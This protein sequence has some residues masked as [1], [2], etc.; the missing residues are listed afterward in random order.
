MKKLSL[1]VA[2]AVLSTSAFADSHNSF[3][4]TKSIADISISHSESGS[5]EI[6]GLELG[7]EKRFNDIWYLEVAAAKAT[8]KLSEEGKKE[9]LEGYTLAGGA[10]LLVPI[11]NKHNAL[12][13]VGLGYG[14][15]EI[16]KG[17]HKPTELDGFYASLGF[18]TQLSSPDLELHL[19][20]TNVF[21]DKDN[22]GYESSLSYGAKVVYLGLDHVNLTLG[23]AKSDAHYDNALTYAAGVEFRY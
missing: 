6:V 7:Y 21:Y 15:S 1:A 20:L 12:F 8:S 23:A 4:D 11:E 18:E 22:S 9:T 19:D 13:T 3:Q 2:L 10:G 17:D 5:D 14:V 16:E